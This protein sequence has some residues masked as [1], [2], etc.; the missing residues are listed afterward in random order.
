MQLMTMNEE[1]ILT[2]IHK[3]IYVKAAF[4]T[5]TQSSY[6]HKYMQ[7]LLNSGLDYSTFTLF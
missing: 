2:A 4:A 7:D 1:C 3:E 5:D 6:Y